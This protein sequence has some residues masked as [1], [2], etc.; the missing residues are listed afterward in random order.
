[1]KRYIRIFLHVFSLSWIQAMQY[2]TH[3]IIWML[4]DTLWAFMD[5]IFMVVLIHTTQRIGS[6]TQPQ[7]ITIIG[8]FR[9]LMIIIWGWLYQSF[10]QFVNSVREGKLDLLLT[11]PLNTQFAVSVQKFSFA[12]I[13]SFIT[14]VGFLLYGLHLLHTPL[15]FLSIL[16]FLWFLCVSAVL[17]YAVYFFFSVWVLFLERLNNIHHL[18]PSIFEGSRFPKEI[19]PHTLQHIVLIII[20]IGLMLSIPASALF[21]EIQWGFVALFHG[22]TLGF[23][24]LG[25]FLFHYGLRKYSSASS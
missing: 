13:P 14:G 8:V 3:F 18:F 17:I 6:W 21:G 16:F 9:L 19:F 23:L 7:V 20:P 24:F 5:L 4:V 22:V 11:K 25:R 10:S 15:T 2:R 12:V 1:M